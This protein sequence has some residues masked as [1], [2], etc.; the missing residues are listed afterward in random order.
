M[1]ARCLRSPFRIGRNRSTRP[2]QAACWP[3]VA[4]CRPLRQSPT[5][6]RPVSPSGVKA[7]PVA[8]E[9]EHFARPA[10]RWSRTFASQGIRD[11]QVLAAMG[12]IQRQRFVPA[13][14]QDHA[15]ADAALQIGHG[16]T[17]SRPYIVALDD[18]TGAAIAQEASAGH[19][20][21]I[22]L[23]GGGPRQAVQAC[24]QHRDCRAAG[25]C[26]SET[27]DCAGLQKCHRPLRR[28]LSWLAG[29]A[30]RS[31]SL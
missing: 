5:S 7:T 19:R 29:E 30:R 2:N 12:Q 23:S 22:G 15:Y 13:D 18:G 27:L 31:T 16:Q 10:G 17:I 14:R 8:P 4:R 20:D 25:K 24:I 3:M 1:Y 6:L 9:D 11:E 26:G 28:R 21:R